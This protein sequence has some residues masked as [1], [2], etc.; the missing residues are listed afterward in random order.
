MFARFPLYL[1]LVRMDKPI[2]SL[3]LLWP[4]LNALWIASG[5]RPAPSLLV[6]FILGTLLMRSAGCAIND[7]ADRDFDRHVKRT[8]DRPLTSGKIRAWEAVAIAVGLAI[9]SFLLILPL[10]GLT[11]WLSVVAV[12]VAGTYPFLKRFFA[13]PQAYLGIAFGFGIPMAFAAIQNTVPLIAWVMLAANVFWS[14][15]YDTAYAMVDRDDDLKIGMRTS[16]ITFGRYDV[17]AIMLCY[18]AV[19]AIYAWIGLTQQ[20]GPVYWLGWAAAVGCAVYHYTLIKDRDRMKCFAAFRHNN[21]LGGALFVGI[22]L[23]YAVTAF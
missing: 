5:G 9:V 18:A 2:G 1:K 17:L 12:F 20:F 23:H 8:V 15:A 19:F 7:Y 4:T 10:N 3:L 13:I 21:W 14:V 16:A 6:I 22:A 11:K